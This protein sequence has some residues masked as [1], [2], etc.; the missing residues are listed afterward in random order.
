MK[1]LVAC[2][3]SGIVRD[4]LI[5]EGHDA[6]SCDF[7][8]SE[9]IGPHHQGDVIDILYEGWDMMIAHPDCTYLCSSGL[10]WNKRIPGREEKT[11]KA[12]EFIT[13]L[14]EAPIEKICIENPVGCINTRLDFMPKP[15]YI[16][17]YEFGED[18]SKKTGLWLKNLPHLTPTEYVEPRIV[19]KNGKKYK[20]WGNQTDSGQNR[21]GPSETRGKD[22]A[23]TY[24]G[25]AMAMAEQWS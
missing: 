10:H 16:Q 13:T 12:L 2:E 6:T 1:V 4:A 21:L 7:L 11:L 20:R 22:R 9:A 24:F 17:P 25:I 8:P 15:Q 23:K 5:L 18:A 14:W 19:I 3:Y